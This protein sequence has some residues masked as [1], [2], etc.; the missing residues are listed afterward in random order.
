MAAAD[1]LKAR[2]GAALNVL[3]Q[4]GQE[5]TH[6]SV[7]AAS[8]PS[9]ESDPWGNPGPEIASARVPLTPGAAMQGYTNQAAAQQRQ[10]QQ[11]AQDRDARLANAQRLRDFI[12]AHQAQSWAEL[13]DIAQNPFRFDDRVVV[14]AAYIG[15]V[16]SPTRALLEMEGSGWR[17]ASA[18]LE[19]DGIAQWKPGPRLLAVRVMGRIKSEDELDGQARL[20]LVGSEA[21]AEPRCDDW[22]RLP[23]PLSGGRK[24]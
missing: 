13:D 20:Q 22:R 17:Y 24:P 10:Q 1:K 19:G 21:C 9:L 4:T 12:N 15:K 5:R 6:L 2:C 18:I 3:N 7:R 23:K 16:L 11:Q 8:T 14:T